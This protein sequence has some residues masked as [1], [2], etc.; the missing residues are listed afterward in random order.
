MKKT[1]RA[2]STWYQPFYNAGQQ[3][4]I[5]LGFVPE[6]DYPVDLQPIT[7]ENSKTLT[8][9][10]KES[11]NSLEKRRF[12]IPNAAPDV[13][14]F[15]I[16]G[17]LNDR[18]FSMN[19][20]VGYTNLEI[21][22]IIMQLNDKWRSIYEP[23]DW[24]NVLQLGEALPGIFLLKQTDDQLAKAMDVVN[25]LKYFGLAW[26]ES[27]MGLSKIQKRFL[28]GPECTPRAIACAL[29]ARRFDIAHEKLLQALAK[30]EA[31]IEEWTKYYPS[32]TREKIL[33]D[34]ENNLQPDYFWRQKYFDKVLLACS[35]Q[36]LDGFE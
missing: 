8:K 29:H 19:P 34:A 24:H 18:G 9:Y 16:A 2:Q 22:T 10:E 20:S 28:E 31:S 12:Y 25:R 11:N 15:S 23:F 27:N 26:A 36:S 17:G 5:D 30:R 33:L 1:I 35:S 32:L 4:V 21:A 13:I 14:V 3:G 6:S 7:F